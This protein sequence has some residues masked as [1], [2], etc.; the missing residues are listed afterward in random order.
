LGF[1]SIL[2]LKC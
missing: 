2:H 1:E